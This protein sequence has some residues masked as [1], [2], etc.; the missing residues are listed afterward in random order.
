[1][2]IAQAAFAVRGLRNPQAVKDLNMV[3]PRSEFVRKIAAKLPLSFYRGV[4]V[5]CAGAAILF[6]YLFLNPPSN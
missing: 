4:G 6:F 5:F 3:N 1:M 2:A